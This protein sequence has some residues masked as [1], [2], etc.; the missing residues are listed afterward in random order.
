[1][2]CEEFRHAVGAE[3]TTSAL[4]VLEHAAGCAACARYRADMRAM[5][6]LIHKALSIDVATPAVRAIPAPVPSTVNWRIAATILV[7]VVV[8][9]LAW[10]AYPRQSLAEDIVQHVLFE[11]S[12]LAPTGAVVDSQSV[13]DVLARSG[14]RLKQNELA[15]S[16]A[17]V[18]PF[19]GHEAP[20][21]IVQT[22]D[23]PVTVLILSH[24]SQIKKSR[25]F[26]ERGFVGTLLPAPRGVIAVLGRDVPYDAVS[27]KVL[28]ALEYEGV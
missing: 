13:R 10:L 27:S 25:R 22:S 5:D 3:P 9:S 11:S 24:E 7:S 28:N 4:A 1:M 2:N 18:C 16:F 8:F 12:E 15:V 23:G 6:G 19:R 26:E 17:M 14:V 21:L 20:H